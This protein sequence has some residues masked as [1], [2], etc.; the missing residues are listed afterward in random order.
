MNKLSWILFLLLFS[1]AK[2]V[3]P[4]EIKTVKDKIVE[5]DNISWYVIQTDK[6]NKYTIVAADELAEEI[7]FNSLCK[8]GK[9]YCISPMQIAIVSEFELIPKEEIKK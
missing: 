8:T 6:P 2:T 3:P 9:Y 1:C 4:S 7:A 5:T